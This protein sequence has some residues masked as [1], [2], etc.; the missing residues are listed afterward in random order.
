MFTY[1]NSLLS[2]S[3]TYRHAVRIAYEYMRERLSILPNYNVLALEQY[4]LPQGSIDMLT[5]IAQV[6]N[7]NFLDNPNFTTNE[8]YLT[9]YENYQLYV[10][11]KFKRR[12]RTGLVIH[13][14]PGKNRFTHFTKEMEIE[15]LEAAEVD[16]KQSNTHRINIFTIKDS[17]YLFVDTD[18]VLYQKTL[19]KLYA[20]KMSLIKDKLP[21]FNENVMNF[22][23]ALIEN[24][25]EKF[26]NIV[27]ALYEDEYLKDYSFREIIHTLRSRKTRLLS[28]LNDEINSCRIDIRSY[29]EALTRELER[30]NNKLL[31]YGNLEKAEDDLDAQLVVKYLKKSPYIKEVV[32][33]NSS[34]IILKY[35]APLIYYDD[36]LLENLMSN[37]EGIEYDIL[38]LFVDKNYELMARCSIKFNIE[39]LDA[40]QNDYISN[41]ET[42]IS[43]PHID[44]Y[45][46]FGNH[47][48]LFAEAAENGDMLYALEEVTQAVL[49]INFSD[50][51]VV[52]NMLSIL[53]ENEDKKWWRDKKTGEMFSTRELLG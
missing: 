20:L 45:N 9:S 31:Q 11:Q 4:S 41:S 40:T 51:I 35:E 44:Q 1:Y 50:Y 10:E 38:Q 53:Q 32:K 49:N 19:L 47:S 5:C 8:I 13:Q 15:R 14:T 30:L 27:N 7:L 33:R 2:N 48:E 23:L 6:E 37:K 52:N 46:C 22:V 3:G 24:D 16:F 39:T 29:R 26:V 18:Q 17:N 28:Q 42:A 36:Y 34:S 43:H 21:H 12:N 25:K